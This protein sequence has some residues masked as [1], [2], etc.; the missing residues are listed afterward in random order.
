MIESKEICHYFLIHFNEQASTVAENEIP[1]TQIVVENN[2]EENVS[3]VTTAAPAA[4]F[5]EDPFKN[6][7]YEDPFMISVD[8]QEDPFKDENAN[9]KANEKGNFN[10]VDKSFI[11]LII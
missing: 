1:N 8:F 7:R 11:I 2:K 10:F 9:E 3:T 4:D 6:Y 5:Q